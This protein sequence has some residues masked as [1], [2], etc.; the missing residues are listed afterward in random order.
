MPGYL[1]A[2]HQLE[3]IYLIREQILLHLPYSLA[4]SN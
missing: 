2:G 4:G 1:G 3:A